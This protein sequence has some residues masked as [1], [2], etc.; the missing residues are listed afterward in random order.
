[1]F[2]KLKNLI[3]SYFQYRRKE[4]ADI[5]KKIDQIPDKESGYNS[6][7]SNQKF[8]RNSVNIEKFNIINRQRWADPKNLKKEWESRVAIMSKMIEPGSSIIEFGAG[9]CVLER[10]LPEGCIYTPTDLFCRGSRTIECDLNG[11]QPPNFGCYDYA[12]FSGVLEYVVDIDRLI[13]ILSTNVKTIIA[14]YAVYE[15]NKNNRSQW[16]NSYRSAE[17]VALFDKHGFSCSNISQWRSQ[18][19]YKFHRQE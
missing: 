15:L 1:M 3:T 8:Y 10:H 7:E 14:S 6:A 19:I 4:S 12:F 5:T 18:Y 9:R 13:S 11:D 17:L 2:R 16:I